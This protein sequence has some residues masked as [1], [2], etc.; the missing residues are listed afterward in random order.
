MVFSLGFI[1][2]FIEWESV[3]EKHCRL[4]KDKGIIFVAV[5]NFIGTFQNWIHCKF[6]LS[7]Y[8]KHHIPSMDLD[9]WGPIFEKE[10]FSIV[11]SGYFGNFCFG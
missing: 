4:V 5:P 7:N 11:Y 3:L 1:E 9:S 10:N 2:H 6:D 8:E